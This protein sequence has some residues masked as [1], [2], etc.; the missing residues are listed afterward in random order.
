MER[1]LVG[2]VVEFTPLRP[3]GETWSHVWNECFTGAGLESLTDTHAQM[4][5]QATVFAWSEMTKTVL[6]FL[7]KPRP[8]GIF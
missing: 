1:N 8:E 7:E 5:K 3:P 6:P 4:G 2:L